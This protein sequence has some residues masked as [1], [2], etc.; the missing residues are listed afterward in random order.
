MGNKGLEDTLGF[1]ASLA[2]GED[3]DERGGAAGTDDGDA[4]VPLF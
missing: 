2:A 3:G 4:F 1:F